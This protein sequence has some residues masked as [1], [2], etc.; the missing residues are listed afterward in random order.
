MLSKPEGIPVKQ[1]T[2]LFPRLRWLET[3]GTGVIELQRLASRARILE[4]ANPDDA[5]VFHGFEYDFFEKMNEAVCGKLG[6]QVTHNSDLPEKCEG[7]RYV[8]FGNHPT[9]TAVWPWAYF[10]SRHFATNTVAVGKDS[11][12][13]NPLSKW[14]MGD[15]ML[16]A[17]KGIFINRS[18]RDEALR[19][20]EVQAQKVLTPDTAAV[21]FPDTRRPYPR[22]IRKQN[23]KYSELQT[24]SWMTDT[25]FPKSGGLWTLAQSIRNLENV[26][27]LNCTIVEPIHT[28][29]Y[30]GRLHLDTREICREQLFGSPE[31]IE[32][33]NTVLVKLWKKKNEMIREMRGV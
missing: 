27:F 3:V 4:K 26:R 12:I 24:K 33:L 20:I 25:C 21:I 22:R 16:R 2:P 5:E 23:E 19:A 7:D 31:S 15:L 32:H 11:I 29:S 8:Y 13:K 18:D 6:W 14:A 28:H 9:L 30:G 10:M 17:H 1:A